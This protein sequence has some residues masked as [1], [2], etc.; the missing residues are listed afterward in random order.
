[1]EWLLLALISMVFFSFSNLLIKIFSSSYLSKVSVPQNINMNIVIVILLALVV[2]V[3]V[4]Y[5]FLDERNLIPSK[6]IVLL[7]LGIAVL[8]L[9]GFAAF[10]LA[11]KDGKA[12]VVTAIASLSTVGVALLSIIFLGTKFNIKEIVAI[13][14][15]ILSIVLLVI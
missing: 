7:L 14:F 2:L 13:G 5:K 1:M 11:M 6:Q 12:A 4:S 8:S 3:G 9:L 15:A 10:F